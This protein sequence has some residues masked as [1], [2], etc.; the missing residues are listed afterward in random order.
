MRMWKRRPATH[1]TTHMTPRC[2]HIHSS[3]LSWKQTENEGE[4]QEIGRRTNV[5]YWIFLQ[6]IFSFSY[7]EDN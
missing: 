4:Y 5:I 1:R 7:Y 6:I 2:V 3:H